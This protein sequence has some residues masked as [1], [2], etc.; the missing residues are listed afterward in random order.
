MEARRAGQASPQR[1]RGSFLFGV[2]LH[3]AFISSLTEGFPAF[4]RRAIASA[5]GEFL[6]QAVHTRNLDATLEGYEPYVRQHVYLSAKGPGVLAFF[7]ALK[8]TAN[9]AALRPL[10]EMTAP[11]MAETRVWVTER[12]PD[13][14]ARPA[15]GSPESERNATELRYLLSLIVVVFPVLT[16]LPVFAI[17]SL[18]RALVGDSFGL[19][20]ALMY[21]LVPAVALHVAHLDFAVFPLLAIGVIASFVVGVRRRSHGWIALSAAVLVL[22]FYMTFAAVSIAVLIAAYLGSSALHGVARREAHRQRGGR[23][24]RGHGDV[25]RNGRAGADWTRCVAALRSL[26]TLQLRP[27]SPARLGDSRLQHVLGHGEPARL[28]DGLR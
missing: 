27:G 21:P 18:G 11:S 16:Q 8:S 4:A 7:H 26:A 15:P 28:P 13:E 6:F 10:L 20:A 2:A 3:L 19:L 24:R 17:F 22:F 14:R 1:D 12:D 9:S 23:S 5:H 25:C